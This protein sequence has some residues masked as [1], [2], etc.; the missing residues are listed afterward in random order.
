M[1]VF[2]FFGGGFADFD[3]LHIKSQIDPGQGM[4]A[5]QHRMLGVNLTDGVEGIFGCF[6]VAARGQ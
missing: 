1:T 3:D 4:I 6:G 5:V 2:H